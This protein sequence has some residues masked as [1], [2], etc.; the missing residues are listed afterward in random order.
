M[1]QNC[2]W[3]NYYNPVDFPDTTGLSWREAISQCLENVYLQ[4]RT[5]PDPVPSRPSSAAWST[6]PSSPLMESMSLPRSMSHCCM[7]RQSGSPRSWSDVS[8][9]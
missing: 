2:R 3:A 5:Q 6:S 1:I 7:E 8:L 9:H 4:S